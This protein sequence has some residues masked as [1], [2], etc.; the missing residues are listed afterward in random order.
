MNT[1]D[2]DDDI[3]LDRDPDGPPIIPTVPDVPADQIEIQYVDGRPEEEKRYEANT[4]NEQQT[5]WTPEDKKKYG[6]NV[7]Q[8]MGQMDYRIHQAERERD[9]ALRER[10]AIEEHA[11]TL[12]QQIE[13][14]RHRET[15]LG[16]VALDATKL[17]VEN[18]ITATKQDI[19][20]ILQDPNPDAA[21][22]VD[23]Q[24]RLST[25]VAQRSQVS[26]LAPPPK[27]S[28]ASPPSNGTTAPPLVAPTYEGDRQRWL[29][30]NPWFGKDLEKTKRIVAIDQ[31]LVGDGV[32]MGSRAYWN[33]IEGAKRQIEQ[34]NGN[35]RAGSPYENQTR[36]VVTGSVGRAPATSGAISTGNRRVVQLTQDER[37]AAARLGVSE[38]EWAEQ[39]AKREDKLRAQQ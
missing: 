22:L 35:Q 11:R 12:A 5:R 33:A 32:I 25:L 3:S 18:E 10:Q 39:K 21:K 29:A 28:P 30:V 1:A 26:Q 8:R 36:S 31:R 9:Q 16:G 13:D 7:R 27:A 2:L 37:R 19:A 38:Q 17:R 20:R 24:E 6:K 34:S 4:V 23:A 15:E 14:L